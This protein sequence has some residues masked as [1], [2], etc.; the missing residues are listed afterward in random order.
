[1][2][3]NISVT[4]ERVLSAMEKS[5][6]ASKLIEIS[7]LYYL[8]SLEKEYITKEESE[9]FMQDTNKRIGILNENYLQVAEILNDLIKEVFKG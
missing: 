6:N 9:E 5:E 8:D 4:N 1:M 2:R 3:K 7:I